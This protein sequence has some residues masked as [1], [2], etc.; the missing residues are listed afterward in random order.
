MPFIT[1]TETGASFELAAVAS[2][3]LGFTFVGSANA[4]ISSTLAERMMVAQP[5]ELKHALAPMFVLGLGLLIMV[6]IIV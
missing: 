1:N 2:L 4:E 3:A 5:H 6:T